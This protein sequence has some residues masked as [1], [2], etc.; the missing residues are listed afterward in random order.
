MALKNAQPD[1]QLEVD[2]MILD[3]LL[4]EATQVVLEE[5][6]IDRSERREAQADSDL[7]LNLYH[8]TLGDRRANGNVMSNY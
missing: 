7:A 4:F 1:T 5:A 2:R 8:S 3:Y 6:K